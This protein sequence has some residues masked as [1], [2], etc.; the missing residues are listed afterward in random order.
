TGDTH[1]SAALKRHLAGV[2]LRRVAA[3]LAEPPQ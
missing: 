1:A 2:L 3:R